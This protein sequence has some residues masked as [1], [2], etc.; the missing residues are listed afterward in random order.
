MERCERQS[1]VVFWYSIAGKNIRYF[2]SFAVGFTRHAGGFPS[3]HFLQ[4][5]LETVTMNRIAGFTIPRSI[6]MLT[7]HGGDALRPAMVKG[8]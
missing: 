7:Q 2:H 8:R 1:L 5:T 6:R 3:L 4:I